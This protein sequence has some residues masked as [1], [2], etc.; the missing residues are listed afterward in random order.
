MRDIR[1]PYKVGDKIGLLTVASTHIRLDGGGYEYLCTCSCGSVVARGVRYI[2]YSVK[3]SCGCHKIN[4][5]AKAGARS[6]TH[7]LTVGTQQ[8]R[9]LYD[10]HRQMI[11]RCSDPSCQDYKAWG[12][13]GIS[14]CDEWLD[15]I[16]FVKWAIASGYKVGLTI[17]RVDN[18]LGYMPDN[19]TWIPNC[20]QAKNTRRL[21][22]VEAFG[23]SLSVADWSRKTGIPYRTIMSRLR[24]GWTPERVLS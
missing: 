12:A 24:Y 22:F 3:P 1:K 17:E 16:K 23:E 11:R 15:P 9:K 19:C 10:V 6:R 4:E 2:R 7:G 14:V 21:R 18:D 20:E 8:E 13:R 5:S